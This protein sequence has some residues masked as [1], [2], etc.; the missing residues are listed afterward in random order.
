[1]KT[2]K[3]GED[4]KRVKD[5]SYEDLNKM[6]SLLKEGWNYCSKQE[7]KETF[8]GEKTVTEV[9]SEEKKKDKENKKKESK[10]KK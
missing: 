9:K 6:N 2:L 3:K 7:Y 4:F 5:F 8:K 1:M 10:K